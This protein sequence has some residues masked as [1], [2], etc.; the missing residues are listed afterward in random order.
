[1]SG[2]DLNYRPS[3]WCVDKR[4]MDYSEVSV[5]MIASYASFPLHTVVTQRYNQSKV[6]TIKT[7]HLYHSCACRYHQSTLSLFINQR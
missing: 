7:T 2:F 6:Q 4:F 1:M 5:S 3:Y